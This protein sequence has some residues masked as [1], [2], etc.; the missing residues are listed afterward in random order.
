MAISFRVLIRIFSSHIELQSG[1]KHFTT[2]FFVLRLGKKWV[3]LIITQQ[4]F[5]CSKSTIETVEKRVKCFQI[6][7]I[8]TPERRQWRRSVV[9]NVNFEHISHLFLVFPLLTWSIYLFA[10][11]LVPNAI[12][13][14][15][16]HVGHSWLPG[17]WKNEIF[18]YPRKV[19]LQFSYK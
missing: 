2:I 11:W 19:Q 14:C 10:G 16:L 8:K 17:Y 13:I 9:F 4:T 1:L 3:N 7:T 12:H 15:F 5:T 6:I 18:I